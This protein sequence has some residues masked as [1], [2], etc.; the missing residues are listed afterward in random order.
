MSDFVSTFPHVNLKVIKLNYI[1]FSPVCL[2]RSQ[3]AS[4]F[5]VECQFLGPGYNIQIV[6]SSLCYVTRKT[7]R[8]WA[9]VCV[10]RCLPYSWYSILSSRQIWVVYTWTRWMKHRFGGDLSLFRAQLRAN[11]LHLRIWHLTTMLPSAVCH[12]FK[13]YLRRLNI[14]S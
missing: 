13:D 14:L 11:P 7:R 10:H 1:S 12:L 9:S 4:L 5:Q 8:P 6:V 2:C 3:N